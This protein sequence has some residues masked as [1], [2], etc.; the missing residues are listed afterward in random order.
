[1][2]AP[3]L[4]AR[5]VWAPAMW[6]TIH[7]VAMG[8][9]ESA[10]EYDKA[11]Y[12]SFFTCLGDVVPCGACAA[13]YRRLLN[14]PEARRAHGLGSLDEALDSGR[15]FRWTV[16]LHNAVSREIGKPDAD[17]TP[18][19]AA[20]AILMSGMGGGGGAQQQQHSPELAGR[21]PVAVWALVL[22]SFL[23][24]VIL[25]ACRA[26]VSAIWSGCRRACAVKS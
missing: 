18:E 19:R 20:V 24:L 21:R 8:Y 4:D 22:G 25:F 1:M 14:L 17:W 5:A 12:R 7:T 11:V 16:E 15:L 9:P 23:A 6:R 3:L 26:A 10:S 13:G 2:A